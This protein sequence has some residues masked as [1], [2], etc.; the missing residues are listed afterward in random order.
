MRQRGQ[1]EGAEESFTSHS[2]LTSEAVQA[3][4]A[5]SVVM[6][7][8]RTRSD[9]RD[10]FSKSEVLA[11]PFARFWILDPGFLLIAAVTGAIESRD[12]GKCMDV[13]L[14]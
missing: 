14:A 7:T 10:E 4:A 2:S 6:E 5:A 3:A 9:R 11:D 1:R 12:S 13:I 8:E